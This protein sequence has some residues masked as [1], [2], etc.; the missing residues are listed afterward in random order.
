MGK[1]KSGSEAKRSTS[2]D[3]EYFGK[4]TLKGQPLGAL[5]VAKQKKL[6]EILSTDL[7]NTGPTSSRLDF[8]SFR[9]GFLTASV[10]VRMF[11]CTGGGQA[12]EDIV[13]K[14]G[15]IEAVTPVDEEKLAKA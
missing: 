9:M 11:V 2:D 7:Q 6:L 12:Y 3:L 1:R 10:V 4:I 13:K 5:S 14:L 15:E 8:E